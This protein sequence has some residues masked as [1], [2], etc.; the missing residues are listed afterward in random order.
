MHKTPVPENPLL[1]SVLRISSGMCHMLW[2]IMD[3]VPLCWP[4]PFPPAALWAH[5][6]PPLL[7]RV[8]QI[9]WRGLWLFHWHI[10]CHHHRG[11][12]LTD[13]V[14]LADPELSLFPLVAHTCKYPKSHLF[15]G[16]WQD[17]NKILPPL[18]FVLK[19]GDSGP[20]ESCCYTLKVLDDLTKTTNWVTSATEKHS[21]R[22][23]GV[24]DQG[25][26]TL[27]SF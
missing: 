25:V 2:R 1:K 7:S 21:P 16:V 18:L 17:D 15:P 23:L 19:S 12:C 4:E 9:P 27:G 20:V 26:G 24:Q 14:F 3:L 13:K 22:V 10:R 8:Q 6:S 11:L 5:L